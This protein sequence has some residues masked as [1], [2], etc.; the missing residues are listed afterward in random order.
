M[1]ILNYLNDNLIF[2]D[3]KPQNTH[4]FEF[5]KEASS[6]L[7]Q[8]L[9]YSKEIAE[10]I[11]E[12]VVEREKIS[13][14]ILAENL[15]YPHAKL[16]E[17][18]DKGIVLGLFILSEPVVLYL[19]DENRQK[20]VRIVFLILSGNTQEHTKNYLKLLAQIAALSIN[21]ET[22][23]SL[24]ESSSIEQVKNVIRESETIEFDY[25]IIMDLITLYVKKHLEEKTI[26]QEDEPSQ[27]KAKTLREILNEK[28][29]LKFKISKMAP[30]LPSKLEHLLKMYPEGDIIAEVDKSNHCTAC[31]ASVPITKIR[32]IKDKR[33]VAFC[34][35][36]Q[37]IL[38]LKDHE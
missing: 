37:R 1:S 31:G 22:I 30:T 27:V 17:L 23:A 38:I 16:D 7:A 2:V 3:Y 36:C 8:K 18:N 28:R 6:L 32:I 35:N 19:E 10:K 21:K 20:R 13:S 26:R 29:K 24:I 9:E 4:W 12:A 14:T 25:D 33:T 15:A 11:S 5:L 34:E